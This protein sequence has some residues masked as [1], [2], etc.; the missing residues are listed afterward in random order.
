MNTNILKDLGL[1][2]NEINIYIAG[3]KLGLS[4]VTTFAEETKLARSTAYD[5]LKALKEKGLASEIIKSSSRYFNVAEPRIIL[6]KLQ[7]KETKL[8]QLLPEL[9]ILHKTKIELPEVQFY[10]DREGFKTVTENILKIKNKIVLGFVASKNLEYLPIFHSQFRR[11]RKENNIKIKIIT[12]KSKITQAL[13]KDDKKELRETKFFD[14]IIKNN[15]TSLFIYDNKLAYINATQ[16]EQLGIIT[17][18]KNIVN[19]QKKIF[20]YL[21]KKGGEEK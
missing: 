15:K 6:K 2:K 12:E 8:K 11:K 14:K 1:S 9:E 13:K 20:N 3:L 18:N 10:K 19:F 17:K 4:N 5:S 16:D 21:W 7:E